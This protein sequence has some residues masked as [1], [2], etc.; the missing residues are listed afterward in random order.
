[1]KIQEIILRAM[2][3]E[4]KWYQAAEILD[5]SERQLR[6]WRKRYQEHGYD[7]LFDR[8]RQSP[9]PRRIPYEVVQQVLR[10]YRTEYRGYNVKH[11]HE[12]ITEERGIKVSY[13]WT[14]DLLQEAGL[15]QKA[16]KRGVYRRRRPRKV[17]AGM[18]LHLDG[19]EHRWFQHPDH[20]RQCLVVALDDATS[21]IVAAKFAPEETSQL[22]LEVVREVVSR[23]GTFGALYTDRASHFVYTPRAGGKPDRSKPTQLEQIL[24]ELG[25][26]LIVA[27]SPEAR[28]RGERMFGTLQGRLPM[29]LRRA[30]ARSYEEANT[31]LRQVY[32][33]KHN[34][35]FS[36]EAAEASSAYLPVRDVNLDRVF[37]RR[38]ERVVRRDNTVEFQCRHLQLPKVEEVSTLARRKVEVREH[39]DGTLEVLV[40]KRLIAAFEP[41]E[42]DAEEEREDRG[43]A[44]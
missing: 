36:V 12:E 1:M 20:E 13:S 6:R 18:M 35:Q 17:C 31:Y 33:T 26:E 28:G 44:V 10:L 40:G 22:C 19:S 9:S 41:H 3:G 16:K 15:V 42:G 29:E 38:F 7:G 43:E 5:M 32:L 34:R 8:R 23:R 25:T 21:E 4:L 27:Y 39:L 24:E 11:F 2:A 37:A 14:K 30:G